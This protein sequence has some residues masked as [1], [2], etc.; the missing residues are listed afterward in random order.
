M[1]L[2]D[3]CELIV[4]CPH[5]TAKDEGAGY[6]LIRTPNIGKGRLILD[7]VHRVSKEVYD[8]RNARAIPQDDDLILAREAP[9]GN[10]AIIKNGEKVCLGQR[11]VLIR[12]DK[13]K[14]NPD[15]LTYYILA[16]QQQYELLGTANGATVAHVNIPVIKNLPV[17]LP[18][19]KIQQKAADI[20][21]AYDELI[22]NN[23][24]Q[25]KVLDEASQR[26]YKEWFVELK[27]VGY[28]TCN[29]K[30]GIPEGWEYLPL[31]DVIGY[32][33]GGGWGEETIKAKN[34]CEAYVIRGTDFEGL[35]N[36]EIQG[37]P[38][39]YHTQSNLSARVLQPGDI[40]FE[41]SGGS[42]D[43]GVARTVLITKA[44]IDR[45]GKPVMCASFCKL[46]RPE[47]I[48]FSQYLYDHF[49]YLRASK[50][51]EEFDKR[52]ASSIVNYRWKDFLSQRYILMPSN[53]V[54]QK[55]NTVATWI[56][57]KK[58]NLSLQ[59]ETLKNARDNLLPKLMSGEI[60]L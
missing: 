50:I 35:E 15:F 45:L 47:R 22:E 49:R 6:P 1:I 20:L 9:A 32:E 60:E 33:I 44:L 40:V 25:I 24:W 27:F 21:K 57:E 41:V 34:E 12:P 18:D 28:E 13:R 54:L 53:E 42:R 51:T 3:I 26:L 23:V 56:T 14:V 58:I 39:R 19:K 7:G 10:V 38:L 43:E 36:G 55:Y 11:T 46:V 17:E 30:A 4:D 2:N 31:Q 5:S 8:K 52:S 59:V 48:D 37:I 29:I 16:P